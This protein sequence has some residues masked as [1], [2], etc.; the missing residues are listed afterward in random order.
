MTLEIALSRDI[1]TCLD[2]RRI[3]FIDEQNV[4]FEEEVDGLDDQA[5]HLIAK[6][7]AKPIGTARILIKDEIAKIGRVCV[8]SECRGSGTGAEIIRVALKISGEQAGVRK[9]VLGA[10]I[11]ALSF[12]QGLGFVAFGPV[13]LDAGIEHQDMEINL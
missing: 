4:S 3:V 2:L 8:L 6:M 1:E 10:Q 13:Y 11:H 12:Y 9:A 5:L 7:D